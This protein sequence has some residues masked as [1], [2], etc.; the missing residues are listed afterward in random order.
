MTPQTILLVEDSDED[1]ETMLRAFE[2]VGV[3]NPLIRCEDGEQALD[4]LLQRGTYPQFARVPRPKLIILDLNLP[5]VDGRELI[6]EIKG[7]NSVKNIPV[8]VFTTST[9]ETDIRWCYE[10]GANSFI[11]K[12]VNF[13]SLVK[14]MKVLGDYWCDVVELP[15]R[16]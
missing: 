14:V 6:T 2:E 3:P 9:Q 4:Y 12:P 10:V 15:N 13:E 16:K 5:G 7:A 11:T 1:F 8:I